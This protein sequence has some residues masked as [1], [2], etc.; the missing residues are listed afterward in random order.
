MI[1][2]TEEEHMTP[3]FLETPQRVLS[4]AAG[5]LSNNKIA[6]KECNLLANAADDFIKLFRLDLKH[7]KAS[8]KEIKLSAVLP[9]LDVVARLLERAEYSAAIDEAKSLRA[10]MAPILKNAKEQVANA[11]G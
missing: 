3:E 9:K 7:R 2:S 5:A 4:L 10:G 1:E 11:Q 8:G 6:A